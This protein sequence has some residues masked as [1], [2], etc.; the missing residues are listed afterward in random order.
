MVDTMLVAKATSLTLLL[1]VD[2]CCFLLSCK[3]EA[4][5]TL[6]TFKTAATG[7]SSPCSNVVDINLPHLALDFLLFGTFI[8][9]HLGTK[10]KEF[11]L[12]LK[13]SLWDWIRV[14]VDLDFK[15][16][17][18]AIG[19]FCKGPP[20][21]RVEA[22]PVSSKA[23]F[24]VIVVAIVVVDLSTKISFKQTR[25]QVMISEHVLSWLEQ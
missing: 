3:L 21:P 19:A 11:N 7:G 25:A 12:L 18:P 8:D 9:H 17:T 14:G 2:I 24:I 23:H 22:S 13:L 6:A 1:F 16:I 15:A 4:T 5:V 10:N 20:P